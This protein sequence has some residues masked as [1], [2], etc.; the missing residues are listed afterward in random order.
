MPFDWSPDSVCAV[1]VDVFRARPTLP[2]RSMWPASAKTIVADVEIPLNWDRR[3]LA[4]DPDGWLYLRT[5][6][7]CRASDE[8]ISGLVKRSGWSRKAFENGWRRAASAIASGL[9]GERINAAG[10]LAGEA[11]EDRLIVLGRIEDP[12]VAPRIQL[13]TRGKPASDPLP[14]SGGAERVTCRSGVRR[15]SV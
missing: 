1:L 5:W 14:R 15:A 11:A 4:K 10:L 12:D 6:A 2:V 7:Y 8:S 3:F 13:L 9:N